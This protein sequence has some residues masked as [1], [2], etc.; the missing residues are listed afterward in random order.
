[1]ICVLM[2][3]SEGNQFLS[4]LMQVIHQV[5][6]CTVH[7]NCSNGAFRNGIT[8]TQV[9]SLQFGF[10]FTVCID[11]HWFLWPVTKP[12]VK[13]VEW[14]W[15]FQDITWRSWL[16]KI[17]WISFRPCFLKSWNNRTKFSKHSDRYK[18][19]GFNSDYLTLKYITHHIVN[20]MIASKIVWI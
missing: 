4:H 5:K 14:V 20:Q 6:F 8:S 17:M 2:A 9:N 7:D 3:I 18:L 10:K 19:S 12:V 13:Y 11:F 15:H 16:M 1:M